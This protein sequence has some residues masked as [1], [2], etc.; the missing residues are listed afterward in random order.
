MPVVMAVTGWSMRLA[1]AEVVASRF[2]LGA[3][4]LPAASDSDT[5]IRFVAFEVRDGAVDLVVN[6]PYGKA[7][8]TRRLLRSGG[9]PMFESALT[10]ARMAERYPELLAA[11]SHLLAVGRRPA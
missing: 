1:V 6:E 4:A 8:R 11:S 2:N 10:A 5:T 7:R 3:R 9:S